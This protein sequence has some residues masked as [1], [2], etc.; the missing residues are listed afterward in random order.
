M[1]MDFFDYK[2]KRYGNGGMEDAQKLGESNFHW[3]LM[4]KQTENLLK[5]NAHCKLCKQTTLQYLLCSLSPLGYMFAKSK[6]LPG[7]TKRWQKNSIF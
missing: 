1:K 7:N 6:G 2:L 5:I 4:R 3:L